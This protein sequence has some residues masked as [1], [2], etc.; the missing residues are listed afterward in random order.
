MSSQTL[1]PVDS[2][3]YKGIVTSPL[4]AEAQQWNFTDGEYGIIYHLATLSGD[5]QLSHNVI[6]VTC[7]DGSVYAAKV[8]GPAVGERF[9]TDFC[10]SETK[11]PYREWE[12]GFHGGMRLI[13]EEEK[14]TG[15]LR[16]GQNF[17]VKI[18]LN[19]RAASPVWVPGPR[20]GDSE[21]LLRKTWKF[22]HEQAL[23]ATGTIEVAGK[24]VEFSAIG[25]R[26][27]SRGERN[28]QKTIHGFWVNATF[29]SGLKFACFA[30]EQN[31][32]GEF[33]RA[34]VYE[35]DQ[36][37]EARLDKWSKIVDT[38][39]EPRAFELRLVL[40]NGKELNVNAK[41]TR[42]MNWSAVGT[43]EWALG[44]NV[45]ASNQYIYTQ[46]FGEFECNG[47]IGQGFVDRGARAS[48][49]NV[50]I[51]DDFGSIARCNR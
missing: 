12:I 22:H 9:G 18:K 50:P 4:W 46:Y 51:F 38:H 36:I 44:S 49:L 19:V 43:S 31:P 1:D 21:S 29:P 40:Q 37:L 24:S 5:R 2:Y 6:A 27:H 42:G 33:E 32:G 25:H 8:V 39:A 45:E 30:G 13:S 20:E 10:Y 11:D 41:C 3:P 7:P 16:D 34:A 15:L 28:S 14:E 26:D 17:P 35:G 47:E 48:L 23:T